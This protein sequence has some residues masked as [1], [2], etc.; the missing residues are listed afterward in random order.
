MARAPKPWFREDRQAYF[1]TIC[2]TR[3]NLGSDKKEADRRFHELMAQADDAHT[4]SPTIPP[5]NSA[6]L[7]VGEVFEKFLDWCQ[8]HRAPRTYEWN[9]KHIQQFCDRLKVART[10]LAVDLRPFHVAEWVDSKVTWGANQKRGAIIALT[11]PFNWAAKLGY[12]AVSPVRGVEKPTPTKRDSRM[13]PADFETLLSRVKDDQFRDLLVFAFEAGCR[14]QEARRIEARHLKLD[15]HR[16]EI[17]PVES[18][19]KKRWRVIYLSDKAVALV[20]RLAAN[21]P[22][23]ALFLNTDGNPWKAQAVV[24]R[25]QRLLVK[26]SGPEVDLPKLPRYDHRKYQDATELAAARKEHQEKLVALRKK[27]ASLARQG[28]R[29]FAMYDLR[30]CFATR[31]LKEGHDPITV[32]TLLG[33]KDASMLCKHYVGVTQ[34]VTLGSLRLVFGLAYN[35]A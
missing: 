20:S 5:Q 22:T 16:I 4:P 31:K 29:R 21:R 30:H 12:I 6:G 27:R 18:K 9:R 19:G 28:D 24:C 34:C 33:H 26:L 7:T 35:Q 8:N 1:V 2:G 25:F 32:A 17:P 14:P 10:M 3:H 11:R 23:G 15:Q 13:T